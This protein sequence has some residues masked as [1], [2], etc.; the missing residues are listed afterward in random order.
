M[1]TSPNHQLQIT[2]AF[3]TLIGRMQ[4]AGPEA[5]N[6]QLAALVLERERMSP[7]HDHA[8]FG[9]WHSRTDLF[10]WPGE[11]VVRLRGWITEALQKV[12]QASAQLPES[13]AR[14]APPRGSFQ[15]SAW[16]KSP[17]A[18]T[19]TGCTTTRRAPGR[20]AIT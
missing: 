2:S 8:N 6:E 17:A 14:N 10:D 7:S 5:T 11:A 9:G 15:I 16:A 20:V 12:V 4:A 3:P 19:T 13:Q 18:E 1:A